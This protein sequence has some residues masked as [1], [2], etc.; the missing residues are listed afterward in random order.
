MKFNDGQY[1]TVETISPRMEKTPE[2]F[3]LC[4]DVPISRTGVF[5]YSAIEAGIEAGPGGIVK[6]SRTEEEL[7]NPDAMRSFEGKPVVIGHSEFVD[8]KNWKDRSIGIVQNV[9][10]GEGG[11]S[12]MLLA[13]LLLTDA[14][15]IELV[16]SGRLREVS[17]GYDANP[18]ADGVG[19]GHQVGIV[20]NHVA[21]VP[22]GRCGNACKIR[23][24]EMTTNLKTMLRRLFKDGDEEKFN[25]TLDEI[26]VKAVSDEDGTDP[27]EPK[28]D[29]EKSMEERLA[30]LEHEYGE[31]GQKIDA[32]RQMIEQLMP[33][34]TEDEEE[35]EKASEGNDDETQTDP[36]AEYVSDEEA[37]Q[38]MDEA[39]EV[40]PGMKRPV[41]DSE[42]GKFTVAQMKRIKR[43]A[44][45]GAGVKEFGDAATLDGGELNAAFKGV[46]LAKRAANN[47]KAK[48]FGDGSVKGRPSN[49]D[50][51][52]LYNN[53]WKNKE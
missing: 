32:M 42:D 20:G 23:D 34:K 49:A 5:D 6:M 27:I 33:K 35:S 19:Q 53:F 17:C 2:G 31:M 9:R 28:A 24:G 50:L 39:E 40:C 41:G 45:Q 21:L 26:E 18:V 52:K 3:L 7:F 10:R 46:L 36:D 37:K 11:E 48:K 14:K 22:K 1:F 29:S 43:Q 15:G 25:E 16:E 12:S 13:D 51:N 30:V 47:P 44:L 8:P 4:R 38:T